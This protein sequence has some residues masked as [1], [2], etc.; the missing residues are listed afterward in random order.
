M[1]VELGKGYYGVLGVSFF[2]SDDE[3]RRAYRKLAMVCRGKCDSSFS[4]CVCFVY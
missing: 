2:S 1:E 4:V 3:I